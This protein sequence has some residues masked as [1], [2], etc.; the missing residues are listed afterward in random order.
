MDF[1][2]Y[3]SFG[4]HKRVILNKFKKIDFKE[5]EAESHIIEIQKFHVSYINNMTKEEQ[6]I[7][8][9]KGA[10]KDVMKKIKEENVYIKKLDK[11]IYKYWEEE[12]I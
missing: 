10:E 2:Y 1:P 12:K 11:A 4:Y 7:T 3:K 9:L 5:E 8:Y 6:W